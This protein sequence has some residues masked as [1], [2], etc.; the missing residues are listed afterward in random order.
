MEIWIKALNNFFMYYIFIYSILFFISTMYSAMNI[1]KVVLRNKYKNN[2]MIKNDSNYIPVSILVPAYN[3]EETI[4]DCMKSMVNL[5]YP[6]YEIIIVNDGSKDETGNKV[7][8]AFDLKRVYKPIRRLV[9]SKEEESVYEGAGKVKI[10]LINKKNGGKADALN[11]GINASKYPL[12]VSL[13]ADSVLQKDSIEKMIRPFLENHTMV[14]VG[15][16]IQISNSIILENG[17]IKETVGTNKWLVLMQLIEYYRVFLATRILFNSFNGN[18]IISGA[19]GMFNKKAVVNVGGYETG[20]IGEDMEL[21]M[22]LHSFHRKNKLKYRIEYASEAICWSQVPERFKDLRGQRRRWHLGLMQSLL[23]HK[24]IALNFRYGVIGLFSYPYYF[25]YEMISPII[26]FFGVILIIFSYWAGYI[27][28][29]FLVVFIIMYFIYNLILSCS[30]II[31]ETYFLKRVLDGKL[32]AKLIIFSILE[33]L[34]YRQVNSMI[35]L[36]AL[37]AYKSKKIEWGSIKRKKQNS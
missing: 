18:L 20:S 13:D 23:S 12:F 25:I 17:E 19:F 4:V 8:E 14:A 30:C 3:E 29:K 35:R 5:D 7:I 2:Y 26:E 1:N 22:R 33:S 32:I 16:N 37:F 11:M 6:K 34:G 31:L 21:V 15:G 24:Y 36:K 10:T 27:N 28:L 9:K